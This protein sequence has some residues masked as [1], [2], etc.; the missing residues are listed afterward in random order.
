[1]S[2][3]TALSGLDPAPILQA[4]I[5]SALLEMEREITANHSS[6]LQLRRGSRL[7]SAG[8]KAKHFYLLLEGEISIFRS[9]EE[10]GIDE[11]ARFTSGDIIGDFDFARRGDFDANAEAV[12]DSVVILFPAYGITL[13]DFARED[14]AAVSRVLLGSILMLTSRIKRIQ[15]VIV[16][17]I[18]WV[19][20]LNRR[21]YE[22]P[23]TGLW[24]QS[25][26]TDEL[27][28]LL[29]VPTALIILKPDRFQQLLDTYG[30]ATGDETMVRI[31]L[32]LKNIVRRL[33]RGY[34]LR[35]KSN[36]V[37]LLMN[38]TSHGQAEEIAKEM[39]AAITAFK[40]LPPKGTEEAYTF[41]ATLS[42]GVWPEDEPLWESFFT[43]NFSL[44]REA[45][46]NGGNRIVHYQRG[47]V[48]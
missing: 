40:P 7:F 28:R 2:K 46:Q 34:A 48:K 21:A 5:F 39:A 25:Y 9:Q 1:M 47:A 14:P 29:E 24:R 20:E 6:I 44:L 11:M 17:N 42:Y 12:K 23:V 37:G 15:K 18:S 36:E 43:G 10:G 3:S 13:E 30:N 31:A 4:E 45:R 8:E 32:V 16:E 26:L 27:N 41:S 35:F 38:K 33:G 19:Q 22:D